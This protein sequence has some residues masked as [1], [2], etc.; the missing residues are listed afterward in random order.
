MFIDVL[1]GGFK[2][3]HPHAHPSDGK[4]MMTFAEHDPERTSL[5]LVVDAFSRGDSSECRPSRGENRTTKITNVYD[6]IVCLLANSGQ[7]T[8]IKQQALENL[9]MARLGATQ[10]ATLRRHQEVMARLGYIKMVRGATAF[11]SAEYDLVGKKT[12]EA[13][14]RWT[15]ALGAERKRRGRPRR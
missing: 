12:L 10:P 3:T 1:R 4:I 9:L 14:D 15:T 5:N 2:Y 7:R 11:L 8:G 13:R 6:G